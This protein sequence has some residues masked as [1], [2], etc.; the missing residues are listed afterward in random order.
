MKTVATRY[1]HQ[2]LYDF[3]KSMPENVLESTDHFGTLA[4]S[5]ITLEHDTAMV[6]GEFSSAVQAGYLEEVPS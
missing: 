6:I 2:E 3:E 1:T 4:T 5:A